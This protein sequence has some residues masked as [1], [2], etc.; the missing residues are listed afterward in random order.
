M[1]LR[2]FLEEMEKER[3]VVH[4]RDQASPRFEVS[5]IMKAFDGGPILF[6]EDVEGHDTRI[7]ANV[8]GTRRRICSALGISPENLYKKLITAWRSPTSPRI[9]RRGPVKEVVENA[10][11]S[12][13]PV[14]THFEKDAGAYITSAIVSARSSDGKIENVSIHRLLIL[15]DT[16]LAI[17]L[18][19]RQLFRLW[20]MAKEEKR[21]LEVAIAIGL[22]PAVLLAASAPVPFGVSEFGIAN[23]LLGNKI[24][25]IECERVGAYAPAEAE[26]VLEGVMST[27]EETMEGPFVDITGTYDIQRSQPIIE[28]VG[29]MHR[30]D[31]L[32]QAL[33]PSGAEHKL[34]MGLPKE[35]VIWEAV[36]KVV[37]FVKAVNLSSGGAG[38]L[39]AIISIE[40]QTEGDG[41][42]AL[43]AAFGAHSSLKHA[44]VVDTD[45]DV[46]NLEEVEWAIATR[47]QASEGLVI[48]PHARGSTL[49]PS[50]DQETALTT[51][52]GVDATRPLTKP[53]ENFELAKIPTN[54][55]IADIVSK[56]QKSLKSGSSAE[57][58]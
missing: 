40:K 1:S 45:I 35:V 16:H 12:R 46:F 28:L 36:A 8:C 55:E 29:M 57:C 44:V 41:K 10:S 26:I 7:V 9:V 17:R 15:D 51:K 27:R 50:A 5:S 25:L 3:E 13:L 22:H 21:D 23:A 58:C 2:S 48:I 20:E 4:V 34:L 39:H 53:Y 37:P 11:L 47:F 49:D 18:V 24:P 6:F 38:W 52:L 33:L 56:I 30:E 42:N 31:Y 19:P 43:L 54:K 14:L 32:Y